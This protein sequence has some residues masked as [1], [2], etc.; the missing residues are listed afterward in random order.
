M[1]RRQVRFARAVAQYIHHHDHFDLLPEKL[2]QTSDVIQE[3]FIIVLFRARD[4]GLNRSLV[5]KINATSKM[6]VSGTVWDGEPASRI[7]VSNWQVNVESDLDIVKKVFGDV[8]SDW[9][10]EISDN[11]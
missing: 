10:K 7:A 3:V 2:Q 6:Y 8:I 9:K 1:L 11:Y 5:K 4:N